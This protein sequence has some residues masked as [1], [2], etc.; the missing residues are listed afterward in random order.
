[1]DFTVKPAH[2]RQ[3]GLFE[4]CSRPINAAINTL[5]HSRLYL[6]GVCLPMKTKLAYS[7][8]FEPILSL[9]VFVYFIYVFV[10]LLVYIFV[11]LFVCWLEIGRAHV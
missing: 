11:H 10:G 2:H 9:S 8:H 7:R 1:M 4:K 5:L 3:K 6:K